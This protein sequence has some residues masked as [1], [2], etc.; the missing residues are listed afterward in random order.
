[1]RVLLALLWMSTAHADARFQVDPTKIELSKENRAQAFQITNHGTQPLRVQIT[2][3]TWRDDAD[4]AMI[5]APTSDIVI[6]P[7]LVVIDP[8]ASR[9]VRVATTLDPP[10]REATYRV[11]VEELPDRGAATPG[12]IRVLARIGV[13][14]FVAPAQPKVHVVPR[15]TAQHAV[16]VQGLGTQHVKLSRV[17]LRAMT[18]ETQRWQREVTGWYVLPQHRRVFQVPLDGVTCASGERL[19]AE[20]FAETGEHWLSAP[21][22]CGG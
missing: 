2:A 18:K 20:V 3:N 14:V 12:R 22:A 9:T 19:V 7:S 11:F 13:P 16:E 5:L 8:G 21:L 4:G 6:R 17:V 10:A 1:M 15:I